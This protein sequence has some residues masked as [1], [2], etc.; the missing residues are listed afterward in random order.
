MDSKAGTSILVLNPLDFSFGDIQ[1]LGVYFSSAYCRTA[2][3]CSEWM[4]LSL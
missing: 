3:I 2:A 4:Y 1:K